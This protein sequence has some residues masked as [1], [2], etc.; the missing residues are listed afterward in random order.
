MV[1]KVNQLAQVYTHLL[2]ENVAV[3]IFALNL[4]TKFEISFPFFRDKTEDLEDAH[5]YR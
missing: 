4:H 1:A 5:T 3:V 2:G